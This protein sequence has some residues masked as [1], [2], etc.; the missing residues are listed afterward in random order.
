MQQ[1]SRCLH[2]SDDV[3][4]EMQNATKRTCLAFGL[5]V[6]ESTEATTWR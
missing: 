5:F 6:T 4:G 1:S 2:K 3:V